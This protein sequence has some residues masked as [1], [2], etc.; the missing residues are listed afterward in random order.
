MS[1]VS[2]I[3]FA[4][5]MRQ[6]HNEAIVTNV[7]AASIATAGAS[8]SGDLAYDFKI[9]QLAGAHLNVQIW[10]HVIG[11]TIGAVVSV[12]M[13]KIFT[14]HYPIPGSVFPIPSSFIQINT[15]KLLL[16]EGLP[17]GALEYMVGFGV[18]FVAIAILKNLSGK[19]SW[20][21][22]IPSGTSVAIGKLIAQVVKRAFLLNELGI[23]LVP[24]L[25]IARVSGGIAAWLC[26]HTLRVSHDM[27]TVVGVSLILGEALGS[28]VNIGLDVL[29]VSNH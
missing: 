14:N 1:T 26:T 11:S 22:L 6:S 8:Q 18:L 9:G 21:R 5:I 12:I 27:V 24:A 4:V 19:Q 2:Q 23:Y 20:T 15:A 28:A 29:M 3:L 25:S 13:Y 10:A 16:A 7:L 17:E